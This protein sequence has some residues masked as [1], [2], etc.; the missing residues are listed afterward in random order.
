MAE[1]QRKRQGW[2]EAAVIFAAWTVFGLT[3]ASQFHMQSE[4]VG[5]PDRWSDSLRAALIDAYLWALS[6]VAIFWLARRVP[7]ARG[8]LLV[9]VPVH[10]LAAVLLGMARAVCKIELTRLVLGFR[11]RPF[12]VVF[13][14]SVSQD[15]I[16][17]ALLLGIA[18]AVFYHDRYRERER[19]AERLAAG[20][21]EARLLA[22]KTQLQPHFL[23]NTLNAIS[24]LI[25]P[26][27]RPAR[28]MVAHLGD[29][30]RISLEHE[31]THEVTLREELAS[32]QPYLEIEQ[33]RLEERLTVVTAIA[34]E[35]LDARVPHMLLQ[36]LV[37]NAI[38]HG[39][40]P[41]VAPGTVAISATIGA[42]GRRVELEV[43]DDGPGVDGRAAATRRG[44]GLTNVRSRLE[45]LYDGQHRFALEN[46]PDGGTVARISLPFHRGRPAGGA[47]GRAVE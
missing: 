22:L 26:E 36:P 39:I 11:T 28:R 46:H 40:A 35:T 3:L 43:R 37:E 41:R 30:L 15:L 4:L 25:P 12:P 45:Q 18:Y 31:E 7:L 24:A 10:L 8:R 34:P 17:Y 32:L 2:L 44:V 5:R 20:L 38:R 13:W 47:S 9:G 1:E 23:F 21:T 29:L 6:T 27:A 33:A 42:D 19:A 16:Y 14:G